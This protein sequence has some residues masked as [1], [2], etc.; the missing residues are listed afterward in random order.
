VWP[1]EGYPDRPGWSWLVLGAAEITVED[2]GDRVA[3]NVLEG[4]VHREQVR[5]ALP[6]TAPA[7]ALTTGYNAGMAVSAGLTLLAL[8]IAVTVIRAPQPIPNPSQHVPVRSR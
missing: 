5:C 1:V 8:L 2:T 3:G 7:Q 4:R 6:G